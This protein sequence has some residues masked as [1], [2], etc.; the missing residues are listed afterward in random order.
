MQLSPLQNVHGMLE[1]RVYSSYWMLL[2]FYGIWH[3]SAQQ[4]RQAAPGTAE[5]ELSKWPAPRVC[6][7]R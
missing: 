7:K 3:P 4:H 1:G 2:A 5:N 6:H